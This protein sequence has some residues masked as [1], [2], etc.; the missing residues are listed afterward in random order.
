MH[1]YS[2]ISQSRLNNTNSSVLPDMNPGLGT[3][4]NDF[5]GLNDLK[6]RTS[7]FATTE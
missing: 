6:R 7:A 1:D 3:V 5:V 4:I 2:T